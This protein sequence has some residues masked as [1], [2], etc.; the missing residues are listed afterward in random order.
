MATRQELENRL[1]EL[2]ES[3]DAVPAEFKDDIQKEID[4]T[5]AELAQMQPS[6]APATESN[7]TN[8]MIQ[9]LTK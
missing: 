7:L 3:L 2:T 6:S 8:S 4:S 9:T 5:R 1:R